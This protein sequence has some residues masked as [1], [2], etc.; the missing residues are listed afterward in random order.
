[1]S[2]VPRKTNQDAGK[3]TRK[4]I[5][6][7]TLAFIQQEGLSALTVRT[8]AERA[9]VN[10]A[11]VNYH[12]GS[13]EALINEVMLLLTGGLQQA[14]THLNDSRVPPAKRLHRFLDE[15]SLALLKH[16]TIYRQAIGLGFLSGDAKQQYASFVRSEGIV[17]LRET[18]Q[19]A[20]GTPIDE[21]R[22]T[23]RISQA[24]GGLAYPLLVAPFLEDVGGLQ[25]HDDAVRREHVRGC[26]EA[27]LRP[28]K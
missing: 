25:F 15:L 2:K 4:Q 10:V 20:L 16:A 18:V 11:A 9:G 24:I 8:I 1:M 26:L 5:L 6:E 3:A 28:E 7:F 13:K 21:L 23:L 12:F 27:L 19:S 14:F 17:A 22:L